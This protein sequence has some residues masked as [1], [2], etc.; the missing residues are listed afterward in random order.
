MLVKILFITVAVLV[1]AVGVLS[2]LLRIQLENLKR[3]NA[4][5]AEALNIL[6]A[7]KIEIERK[8]SEIKS[9]EENRKNADKKIKAL[10]SGDALSNAID[11][12]SKRGGG[13][14]GAD[15]NSRR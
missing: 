3:A 1:V 4:N 8:N 10:R 6:S 14:G 15:C 2:F 9:R 7:A 13:D 5:T 12:L 11:G